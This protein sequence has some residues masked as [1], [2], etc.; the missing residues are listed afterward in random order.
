MPRPHQEKTNYAPLHPKV[1]LYV[2]DL[3]LV[4]KAKK[5][6]MLLQRIEKQ[7]AKDP[8]FV[9]IKDYLFL[10]SQYEDA[11]QKLIDR[12]WNTSDGRAKARAEQK[13][14]DK[15]GRQKSASGVGETESG[16]VGDGVSAADPFA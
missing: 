10:V 8:L 4:Y 13:K 15:S 12:G 6:Y 16:S 2:P 7:Q 5:V 11:A 3:P 1:K 9:P 14:L